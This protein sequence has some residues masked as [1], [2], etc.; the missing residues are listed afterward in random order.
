MAREIY[1]RLKI[2]VEA[3]KSNIRRACPNRAPGTIPAFRNCRLNENH[4]DARHP[5]EYE[6]SPDNEP[7]ATPLQ[8]ERRRAEPTL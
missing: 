2:A 4:R 5:D 7:S 3:G 1:E 6:I 8:K